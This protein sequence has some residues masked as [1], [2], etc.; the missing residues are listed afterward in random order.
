MFF[1]P[2]QV[3]VHRDHVLRAWK[4]LQILHIMRDYWSKTEEDGAKGIVLPPA[5]ADLQSRVPEHIK[6]P[7][8]QGLDHFPA[9][10][11]FEP[12]P[13]I[14]SEDE[15]TPTPKECLT[16]KAF[17][18]AMAKGYN[19][20]GLSVQLPASWMSDRDIF[21]RTVLRGKMEDTWEQVVKAALALYP[22]GKLEAAGTSKSKLVF[23]QV[24]TQ[25]AK[26]VAFHNML[27][28]SCQVSV[29]QWCDSLQ[30]E[31]DRVASRKRKQGETTEKPGDED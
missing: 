28:D 31:T 15:A 26:R 18:A 11:R 27:V 13:E 20:A 16:G 12:K 29:R 5:S 10:Q 7:Q 23:S 24:P 25:N 30:K 6:C 19:D 8:S 4:L 17:D 2:G 1:F 3:Q 14:P 9:T 21:R 22:I